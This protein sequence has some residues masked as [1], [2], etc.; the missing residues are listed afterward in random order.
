M[1]KSKSSANNL[2]ESIY[3]E[4]VL[5]L[6][7]LVQQL[8]VLNDATS[9]SANN[10]PSPPTNNT[11]AIDS[12]KENNLNTST[13]NNN[14]PTSAS[15]T[16]V[17]QIDN[18]DTISYI[19]KQIF[20][21]GKQ[22]AFTDQL[23]LFMHRKEGEIERMCNF[24]YQEFVQSVDQLLKVRAGAVE[25]KNKILELNQELQVAGGKMI[26]KKREVIDYR[27]R[28]LNVETTIESF[29]KSMF[30]LEIA[31]KINLHIDNRKFYA[32]L[33]LLDELQSTH[34]RTSRQHEFAKHMLECIPNLRENIKEEISKDMKDW[35]INVRESTRKIGKLC[36]ELTAVSQVRNRMRKSPSETLPAAK[37]IRDK[38]VSAEMLAVDD[39]E[40]NIL[41][42]KHVK[43]DFKPLHS[44]LHIYDA[45]GKRNDFK[46]NYEDSRRLQANLTISTPFS[47][48]NDD[49]AGFETYLQDVIGF[50]VIEAIVMNT[51]ENF[52][53]RGS[54]EALW[55][56]AMEKIKT[57]IRDSLQDCENPELFLTIK[58]RLTIFIQA[59]ENYGY[60]VSKL[61]D[62]IISLFDRYS[63]MMKTKCSE[64]VS[65]LIDSD[66]YSPL[67][68]NNYDEY[69]QVNKAFTL[70]EDIQKQNQ[71][72]PRIV[73]FSRG[74][75]QCCERIQAFI[76]GFY[77]FAE[78]FS[79]QYGEMDD[80]LKKS[81]ESL[82][83]QHVNGALLR[84]LSSNNL[85]AAVQIRVNLDYWE[86]A[87][88][89][90][91][92]LLQERRSAHRGGRVVLQAQQAFRNSKKAAETR[93]TELINIKIDQLLE[94]ADYEWQVSVTPAHAPAQPS[95]YLSDVA[96]ITTTVIASTVTNLP[97]DV[98]ALVYLETFTHLAEA[99]MASPFDY[100]TYA[101]KS[102][103][104]QLMLNPGVKKLNVNFI[105]GFAVDVNFLK[106]FVLGL[107]MPNLA[108][109]FEELIQTL[110][111]LR[112]DNYE[113]YLVSGVREQVYPRMRT[114]NAVV[115]LEKIRGESNTVF[116]TFQGTP[117]E[118]A[119]R[120]TLETLIKLMRESMARHQSSEPSTPV[121]MKTIAVYKRASSIL[122]LRATGAVDS[123]K[124][125]N[126]NTSTVCNNN[127][128]S[129]ASATDVAQ[130]DNFDTIS[131]IEFETILTY[132]EP[133]ECI[134]IRKFMYKIDARRAS[135]GR[136]LLRQAVATAT[137]N[138]TWKE[139]LIQRSDAGKPTLI[140]PTLP[141]W[142]FN[143]SHHGSYVTLSASTTYPEIGID[144]TKVEF[145]S[146]AS[147]IPEFF[148]SL[149][150]IFTPFEWSVIEAPLTGITKEDAD[151]HHLHLFHCHWA[152]KE[153]YTK[154]KGM[155]LG[156][157]LSRIEFRKRDGVWFDGRV[158]G[159]NVK[160]LP[161]TMA[162]IKVYLDGKCVTDYCFELSYLDP[163]HPVSIAYG[164]TSTLE[165]LQSYKT[166]TIQDLIHNAQ[167]L[168]PF[169]TA[170]NK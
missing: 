72:F 7:Q 27:R 78:G 35:L 150:G 98:Q 141:T 37:D 30:V 10:N 11:S 94:L 100:T 104:L 13:S 124:E 41:D 159:R 53:S 115:L 84:Q 129:A 143:I 68:I 145:P 24:H 16:N 110:S 131:H 162:D 106:R 152:L 147:N 97:P 123:S 65:E 82:L 155:G 40:T 153:S 160:D 130:I 164:P 55:E 57:V 81:L 133:E 85:S 137:S 58:I 108:D 77:R 2:S 76:T 113:P 15:A 22:E 109:A 119:K 86:M 61:T 128:P 163:T 135:I 64:S 23:N 105:S 1:I 46:R 139:I 5:H 121:T 18:F 92:I 19:I 134:R 111:F 107:G 42:N 12:S 168:N 52:R 166:L 132:I 71:R 149:R 138:I 95:S 48:K 96:D 151:W 136:L 170:N 90:F 157:D 3:K 56:T 88:P 75:P 126:I 87:C 169:A 102:S 66:E 112:V 59:L 49:L 45:L 54:V 165:P 114:S 120:K 118:K 32:A 29:Q 117:A 91:E 142:S 89:Q 79:T 38:V 20:Q 146:G 122:C 70:R 67:T 47:L 63:E 60:S 148:D 156:L 80:L 161:N 69:E 31:N 116:G 50:F 6:T 99:L 101:K 26:E 125:D 167:S 127:G 74:F 14:G 73:P 4:E 34:L 43:L 103:D 44:C 144:I 51:T 140:S 93:I 36:L 9:T 28:M 17:A 33:R 158:I 154:A 83:I 62:L 21:S 25:L 39:G 8:A